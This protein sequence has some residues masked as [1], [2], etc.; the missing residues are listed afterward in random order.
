MPPCFSFGPVPNI[1]N[2]CDGYTVG[3]FSHNTEHAYA[4]AD[5]ISHGSFPSP[6]PNPPPLHPLT[7]QPTWNNVALNTSTHTDATSS[8]Y[9]VPTSSTSHLHLNPLENNIRPLISPQTEGC[10]IASLENFVYFLRWS[11]GALGFHLV[12]L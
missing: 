9:P 2:A 11:A 12:P 3:S 10:L 8:A 1:P 6:D 4:G 5:A 7:V